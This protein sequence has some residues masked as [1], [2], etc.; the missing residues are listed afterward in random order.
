MGTKIKV[1]GKTI[2]AFIPNVTTELVEQNKVS[3][4]QNQE[5]VKN[6]ERVYIIVFD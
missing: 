1:G 3:N 4:E 6:V 5:V 2:S